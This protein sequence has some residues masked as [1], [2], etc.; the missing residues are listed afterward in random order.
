MTAALFDNAPLR[1]KHCRRGV[2]M[3]FTNDLIG[4]SLD[5]YGEFAEQEIG[6]Q[7]GL[8]SP[9][10]VVVDVGA[11]IGTHA[12][13][14]A[15]AVGPEGRV[16]SFEP[17]RMIFN[18]LSGNLALNRVGNVQ[19][20]H[21]AVGEAIGRINVPPIQYGAAGAF[22]F[23]ALELGAPDLPPGEEVEVI[24]L[25]SL[26]LARCDFLKIDVE[27]M[28]RQVLAGGVETIRR[29][30]PVIYMENN[31]R[32]NSPALL[33]WLMDEGYRCHWHMIH[34]FNADNFLGATENIFPN[35][36]ELSVLAVPKARDIQI[37]G[38][39]EITDP[40]DWPIP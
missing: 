5:L 11:N 8:L 1:L 4:R 39:P 36:V 32:A 28:E 30:L 26:G 10:G 35:V 16:Y 25:D 22:N 14:Y 27:G 12:L 17:Q 38:L 6:P 13:A 29:T 33:Q 20:R 24:T 19:A 3:F 9:G 7:T 40:A 23:G 31:R 21:A 2:M 15:Q 34:Y 18:M 37:S